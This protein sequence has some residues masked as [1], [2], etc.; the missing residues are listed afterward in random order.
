MKTEKQKLIEKIKKFI[1]EGKS[2][3]YSRELTEEEKILFKQKIIQLYKDG[4][5]I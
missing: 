4:R 3:M 2:T 5:G 1:I